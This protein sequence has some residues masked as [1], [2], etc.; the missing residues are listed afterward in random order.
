MSDFI[1]IGAG[2]IG[3]ATALRL[4]EEG[5]SVTLLERHKA[6]CEA[7]W[8]GGGILS[9]LCPWNYPD[10]VNRLVAFSTSLYPEWTAALSAATGINPEYHVCGLLA[11]PPYDLDEAVS[12]CAAHAAPLTYQ[13]FPLPTHARTPGIYDCTQQQADQALLLPDVAQVRNPRLSQ[14]LCKR[15]K[16]LGGNIIEHCEVQKLNATRQEV[17]SIRVPH[18]NLSA[19][20]YILSAGAWSRN[21]LGEYALNVE[22]KPIRGQILLYKFPEKPLHSVVLQQDLYL[23]PRRDGHLLVGSTT[24]DVGFDKRITLEA[25]DKLSKWAGKILPKLSN[26]LPLRHWSGLRPATPGN[27]PVIGAHP[28]LKNLYVNSG[29]FRYGVTMAL[30]SAEILTNEIMQRAQPFDTT[31]Y[32]QGWNLSG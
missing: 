12:W 27:I 7:S 5:A 10:T 26:M 8:A 19:D 31:P 2:I 21:I 28:F 24:E 32:Q 3:L 15:V 16:Q 6:G 20:R 1:V 25:K 30:G 23:I 22:I 4:L 18:K 14:A 9:P 17:R 11:L 29:H 13:I